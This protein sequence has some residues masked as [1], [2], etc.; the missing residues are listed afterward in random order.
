MNAA[1]FFGMIAVL[2]TPSVSVEPS[3][4]LMVQFLDSS[5]LLICS[6]Y[7]PP[8]QRRIA[9]HFSCCFMPML[10]KGQRRE[11]RDFSPKISP[12]FDLYN[13][14]CPSNNRDRVKKHEINRA[15]DNDQ[16]S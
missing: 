7:P 3:A 12:H 9:C 16:S 4:P 10:D 15:W 5:L 8:P 11:S 1:F 6:H 2:V 14:K 13:S